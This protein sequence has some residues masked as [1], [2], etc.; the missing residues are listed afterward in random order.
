MLCRV[1]FS[2]LLRLPLVWLSVLPWCLH[3]FPITSGVYIYVLYTFSFSLRL[4]LVCLVQSSWALFMSL[5]SSLSWQVGG[6]LSFGSF[7]SAVCL[8]RVNLLSTFLLQFCSWK[9][10]YSFM[11]LCSSSLEWFSLCKTSLKRSFVCTLF[12]ESCVWVRVPFLSCRTW[13]VAGD[14]RVCRPIPCE[15]FFHTLFKM[16]KKLYWRIGANLFVFWSPDEYQANEKHLQYLTSEWLDWIWRLKIDERMNDGC[17]FRE[18]VG[19]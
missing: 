14:G 11:L 17:Y 7:L 6:F 3:L 15:V 10:W 4:V 12:H 2:F 9:D 13:A 16:K 5:S 1:I 18:Y 8:V 19:R